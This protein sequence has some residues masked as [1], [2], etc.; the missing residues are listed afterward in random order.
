[1]GVVVRT[2]GWLIRYLH[3]GTVT[4]RCLLRGREGV[5]MPQLTIRLNGRRA[6]ADH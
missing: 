2:N 5:D 4:S 1:M 3:R 6:T